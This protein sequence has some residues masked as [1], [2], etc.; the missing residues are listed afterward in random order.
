[1]L[2]AFY[3]TEIG[4]SSTLTGIALIIFAIWD[5]TN[6]PIVGFFSDRPFSFT[7]KW[8]RRFPWIIG[9]FIPMLFFFVLIFYPP[10]RADQWI[11]FIW[12]IITTCVFDTLESIFVINFFGLF[13]DKF[14]NRNERITA[15]AIGTYFMV[16]GVIMGGLLPPLIIVFGEINS[17][18]VMTWITVAISMICF[19]FLIPGVRDDKEIVEKFVDNYEKSQKESIGNTLFSTFKQKNFSAF[20]VMILF[21]STFA[22][23]FSS[24]NLYYTRYVLAAQADVAA[25]FVATMFTGA[26]MGVLIW[27]YYVRKTK[28]DRGVMIYSGLIIVVAGTLFSLVPDFN[29]LVVILIIQG[30]GGLLTMM[31]PIFSEV[32]DESVVKTKQRNEGLFGGIRFFVT[33]FSRVL[34]AIILTVVH[35][36][37]G[38]I[39]ASDTQPLSAITGIRFHTGLIPALI[40]LLGVIIFWKFYDITPNKSKLIKEKMKELDL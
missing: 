15:S 37:T 18:V 5:A 13:P 9:A 31:N 1:M 24:S 8:G 23:T 11:I 27:I 22:S 40:M 10:I 39:E 32:V 30:I 16:F 12:L 36:L 17:Y 26:L 38:F 34:M 29:A 33:N 4:L 35:E 25:I 2:F 6:D 3:E 21:Y 19:P 7:K 20:L 28:N 14:R